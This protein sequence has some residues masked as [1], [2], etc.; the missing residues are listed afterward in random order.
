MHNL[1]TDNIMS[2]V[3]LKVGNKVHAAHKLILCAFSDVFQVCNL[4]IFP[5]YF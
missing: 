4:L 1:Y 2:D 3:F 5:Y